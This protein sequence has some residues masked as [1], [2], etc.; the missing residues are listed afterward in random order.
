L[1]TWAEVH[2]FVD[3]WLQENER[4]D[5]H[6]ANCQIFARDFAVFLCGPGVLASL[7]PTDHEAAFSFVGRSVVAA[8]RLLTR[9][10]AEVVA[11][12]ATVAVAAT[13]LTWASLEDHSGALAK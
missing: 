2:A 13:A 7:P 5:I 11:A 8:R 9:Q 1:R 10:D 4:Y 12:G 6:G 3:E